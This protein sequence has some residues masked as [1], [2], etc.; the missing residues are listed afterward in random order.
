MSAPLRYSRGA[1]KADNTPVQCE[2][3]DFAALCHAIRS[4]AGLRATKDAHAPYICGPC[5]IAPDDELH[6]TGGD[7]GSFARAIGKPHRC[8]ECA[9]PRAFIGCDVDAGLDAESFAALVASLHPLRGMVWTTHSHTPEAPRCR[10]LLALDRPAGRGELIRATRAARAIIDGF[11]G[12]G[13]YHAVTWDASCDRPEQ[14]LFLPPPDAWQVELEG[15]PLVLADLLAKVAA[16]DAP[17]A[18]TAPLVAAASLAAGEGSVYGRGALRRAQEAI[19]RAQPGERNA[20]L[21][22][23]AFGLGGLVAVGELAREDVEA[24]LIDATADWDNQAKTR[25]TIRGGIASGMAK[26]RMDRLEAANEPPELRS[27]MAAALRPLSDEEYAQARQP[28]PHA[29]SNGRQG[30][31]PVGEV[32]VLAAQGR[33]GKTYAI[34]A[35]AGAFVRGD[36]VAG[37]SPLAGRSA[38]I[39][40]GEDDP[41]QYARKL[42]ALYEVHGDSW[43]DWILVPRLSTPGLREWRELVRMVERRAVEGPA[44]A[45]LI[46]AVRPLLSGP[47]PPGLLVFETASTLTEADEDNAGHRALIG[48]LEHIAESLGVACVL[49]HHTSQLAASNLPTLNVSVADIRGATALAFNARQCL[50]LVNLGSDDEPFPEADARTLLRQLVAPGD[51]ARITAMIPLDTSKAQN[52]P[53]LFQRWQTTDLDEPALVEITPPADVAG[54]TW[55]AVH[56]MLSGKRAEV[57][58]EAKAEAK[59]AAVA[60]KVA[61]VIAAVSR[62][63]AAGKPASARAVSIEAGHKPGWAD[64]YLVTAVEMGRLS[65]TATRIPNTRGETT[66]YVVA[67]LWDVAA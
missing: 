35:I 29:F 24:A 7:A 63:N 52:P 44:V 18:P 54:R 31:F 56:G 58:A 48:A 22:R 57:R 64:A 21:N 26:P 6:R 14:A 67:D 60:E 2:V 42:L 49:V 13:G 66:V 36:H 10:V 1:G 16:E 62:L 50:L 59:D 15:E 55:R 9:Q 27:V 32:T 30:L 12:T 46:D 17:Y 41:I 25:G 39:Y 33:E 19:A 53:P 23:E 47:R 28:W 11:M 43:R 61:L 4:D 51:G 65:R 20:T 45:A 3:A 5:A 34:T 40:S 37:L 38:I 8:K